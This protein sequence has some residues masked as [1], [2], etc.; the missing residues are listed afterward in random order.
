MTS[1]AC[2]PYMVLRANGHR[3]LIETSDGEQVKS[4]DNVPPAFGGLAMCQTVTLDTPA[5]WSLENTCGGTA[6][7]RKFPLAGRDKPSILFPVEESEE[8]E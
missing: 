6:A 4:R 2:G 3:F 1:K 5:T 8:D 7:R